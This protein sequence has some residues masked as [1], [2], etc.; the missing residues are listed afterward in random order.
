MKKDQLG[1]DA[2][3]GPS[4]EFMRLLWAAD[5]GFQATSKW[6]LATL[7]VTSLQ[8]LV[9]RILGLRPEM[10]A[11]TLAR[12]L[13]VHP[14]TLTGVLQRLERRGLVRRRADPA[15]G[16]RA[17]LSLTVRGRELERSLGGTVEAAVGRALKR[18][19]PRA[20]AQAKRAL[21][22]LTEELQRR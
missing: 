1:P 8:R 14:S 16:R 11:G 13:H 2:E 22:V 19:P 20:V 4:L 6:M 21:T 17:I 18:L 10:S 5:H 3:L 15:D 12:T 9:I 7:G